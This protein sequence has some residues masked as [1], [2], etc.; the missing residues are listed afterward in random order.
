MLFFED[1]E[2]SMHVEGLEMSLVS[3]RYVLFSSLEEQSAHELHSTEYALP[4]KDIDIIT[5][6]R[7]NSLLFILLYLLLLYK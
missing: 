3:S 4:K 6:A 7:S 5:N 1:I 2:L